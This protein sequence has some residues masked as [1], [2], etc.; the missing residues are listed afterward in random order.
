MTIKTEPVQSS[1]IAGIGYDSES[2]TMLVQFRHGGFYTYA[3]VPPEAYRE[4]IEAE[5]IGRHFAKHIRGNYSFK[6]VDPSE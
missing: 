1:N 3:D 5:S 4:L 2:R 6:K